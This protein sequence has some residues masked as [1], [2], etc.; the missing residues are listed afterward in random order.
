MLEDLVGADQLVEARRE[1]RQ[2]GRDEKRKRPRQPIK[3]VPFDELVPDL[4]ETDLVAGLLGSGQLGMLFGPPGCGKTF[5]ALDIALHVATDEEWLGRRVT[6]GVVVYLAAEAGRGID[7]RVY[8]WRLRHQYMRGA[9]DV[10]FYA[11][12]TQLNLCTE[13]E[14]LIDLIAAIRRKCGRDE[15]V[16]IVVD[17]VSRVMGGGQ[18]ND[19]ADMGALVANADVLRE[20]FGSHVLLVHHPGKDAS[21]GARGST[22]LN[23]AVDA[24]IEVSR[25][26]DAKL[27]T[28]KVVKQRDGEV[29][30]KIHFKLDVV[31]VGINEITNEDVTS[32]VVIPADADQVAAAGRE[33]ASRDTKPVRIALSALQQAIADE[34]KRPPFGV[35]CPAERCVAQ[36]AWREACY[37]AGI[38]D[39]AQQA[40]RRAFQRASETLIG[41]GRVGGQKGYVWDVTEA[42]HGGTNRYKCTGG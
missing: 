9:K 41:D 18:E 33:T 21:R 17:T 1:G 10:A 11:I 40:K 36:D 2:G 15:P 23:A 31:K 6:R 5:L 32:C 38:S 12:Q 35:Q 42:V 24:A 22:V 25:N 19:S 29:G 20:E 34:G 7:K 26:E 39:G 3:L 16:L 8:A 30:G 37:R 14:D 28:A 4:S 27:S 13:E